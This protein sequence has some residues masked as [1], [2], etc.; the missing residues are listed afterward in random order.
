MG[1][2]G[3]RG[4]RV[5]ALAIT[6][7]REGLSGRES[8]EKEWKKRDMQKGRSP[9][10]GGEKFS[11]GGRREKKIRLKGKKNATSPIA[12]S[13]AT[14]R[15]PPGRRLSNIPRKGQECRTGRAAAPRRAEKP[16]EKKKSMR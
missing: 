9:I 14:R 12:P 8:K 3:P 2:K 6:E 16:F 1:K 5:E 7:S 15:K 13:S 10:P 11:R 4:M